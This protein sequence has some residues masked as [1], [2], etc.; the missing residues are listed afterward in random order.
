MFFGPQSN[1]AERQNL[2]GLP[3]GGLKKSWHVVSVKKIF[4][5]FD[6]ILA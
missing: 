6:R 1:F 3:T 5:Y 2:E 4:K